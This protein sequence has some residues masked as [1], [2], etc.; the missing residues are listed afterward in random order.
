VETTGKRYCNLTK[1]F[2]TANK[3]K[4]TALQSAALKFTSR[5]HLVDGISG[6][7]ATSPPQPVTK[8]TTGNRT[9]TLPQKYKQYELIA[10]LSLL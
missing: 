8:T 7:A 2:T 6:G 9:I 3:G 4:Q 10:L 1:I 5:R